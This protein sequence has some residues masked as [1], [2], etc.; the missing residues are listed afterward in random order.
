M[1]RRHTIATSCA[2][3]GGGLPRARTTQAAAAARARRALPQPLGAPHPAAPPHPPWS[4]P[5]GT[6]PPPTPPSRPLGEVST[7]VHAIDLTLAEL[8]ALRA[9]QRFPFRPRGHDGAHGLVTF[10]EF[11]GVAAAAPRVV[12][13]YPEVKHPSWHNALPALAGGGGPSIQARVVAALHAAG[14]GRGRRGGAA[15]AARPVFV[16]CFELG[17]LRDMAALTAMPLVLLL[18]GW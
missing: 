14:Y 8:R 18:G 3:R 16:Q 1:V 5:C 15:W 11:L 17:A 9:R 4:L 7:G 12:G 10:Q 13:V 6:A 2:G